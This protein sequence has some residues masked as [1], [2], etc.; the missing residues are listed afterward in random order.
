MPSPRYIRFLLIS[1]FTTFALLSHA[2]AAQSLDDIQIARKKVEDALSQHDERL[3]YLVDRLERTQAEI[4][5]AQ[6]DVTEQETALEE[7]IAKAELEPGDVSARSA[8]LA[9]IRY[10]RSAAK[11]E[12]LQERQDSATDEI[13]SIK[14]HQIELRQQR[15]QLISQAQKLKAAEAARAANPAPAAI[16]AP[17]AAPAATIDI[18]PPA[19][20]KAPAS[21]P[22]TEDE[23]PDSVAFAK[24]TLSRLAAQPQG[25]APLNNV[26]LNHNRGRGTENFNYLGNNLYR[27]DMKL[28]GGM[29][30]FKIYNQTFWMSVPKAMADQD[31]VL[32]YD[33]SGKAKL[34]V[35]RASLLN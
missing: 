8:T 23:S 25:E 21:W 10:N 16:S 7:A 32:I 26:R 20:P 27:V 18:A 28:E 12:R 11:L 30:G 19:A 14:A 17:I 29:W 1:L 4:N 2:S 33:V 35:F 5:E 34:H 6:R 31:F 22:S 15:T 3:A 13:A 24:Q 9:S